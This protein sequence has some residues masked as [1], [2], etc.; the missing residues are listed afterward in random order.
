MPQI[1]AIENFA[2]FQRF[3]A[4]PVPVS[5]Y[6][7]ASSA[8]I[9]SGRSVFGRVGCALCHTPTLR[10]GNGSVAALRNKNA[11]LYSDLALHA[12]GP[13]L[14]D[15]VLQGEARGDESGPR[16]CGDSASGSSSCTTGAP[17]ISRRPSR[18][19]GADATV[20]TVPRRRT[21]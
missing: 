18:P 20:S 2:N 6:R 12:M 3:L 1:G 21:P 5:S 16:R 7:A 15:D 13:G 8:S 9:A 4:P 17:T 19:T 11:H 14:A 10:T